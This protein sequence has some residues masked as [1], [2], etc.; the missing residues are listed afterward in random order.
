MLPP[1]CEQEEEVLTLRR[2]YLQLPPLL[3]FSQNLK[4]IRNNSSLVSKLEL[5]QSRVKKHDFSS[6]LLPFCWQDWLERGGSRVQ[7][8]VKEQWP[9]FA[10]V[11]PVIDSPATCSSSPLSPRRSA[12]RSTRSAASTCCRCLKYKSSALRTF[13][14]T[15]Q[16]DSKRGI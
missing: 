11:P 4:S 7:F 10:L 5:V 9:G 16:L 3:T 12:G 6:F 13:V 1:W 14:V 2:N 15:F 8:A